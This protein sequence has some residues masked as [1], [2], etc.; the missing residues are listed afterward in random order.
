MSEFDVYV[1]SFNRNN[2]KRS[3]IYKT[4]FDSCTFI[5]TNL[6]YVTVNESSFIGSN[7]SFVGLTGSLITD[8]LLRQAKTF[9][10]AILRN[11]TISV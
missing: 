3:F 7:L 10:N 5:N 11:G 2:L 4:K 1:L 6:C 8:Q 9:Q